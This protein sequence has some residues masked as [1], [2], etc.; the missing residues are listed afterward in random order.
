MITVIN[1]GT[2]SG[3]TV[4]LIEIA[5]ELGSENK[6]V[7]IITLFSLE[8]PGLIYRNNV[9]IALSSD[10]KLQDLI[11]DAD[12]II[13]D[14]SYHVFKHEQVNLNELAK[15]N[16]EIYYTVQELL[17]NMIYDNII[18]V[19]WRATPARPF[20]E[21]DRVFPHC[22]SEERINMYL[23]RTTQG[24]NYLFAEEYMDMDNLSLLVFSKTIDTDKTSTKNIDSDARFELSVKNEK[25]FIP[26]SVVEFIKVYEVYKERL[27]Y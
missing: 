23:V 24:N 15:M 6:K 14:D 12:V 26:I 10:V 1:G 21:S 4:R 13:I 2:G 16:K 25:T 11:K 27:V 8:L 20:N 3:K 5:N 17:P 9:I 18:E 19:N 7:L 22:N